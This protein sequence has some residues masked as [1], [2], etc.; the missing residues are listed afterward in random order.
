MPTGPLFG[1]YGTILCQ[2]GE[3]ECE[4]SHQ[5]SGQAAALTHCVSIAGVRS[6]KS[7]R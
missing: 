1:F 3:R 4:A 5:E 7:Q 2:Q 6:R